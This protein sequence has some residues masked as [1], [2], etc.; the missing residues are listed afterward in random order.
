ML[1]VTLEKLTVVTAK[2]GVPNVAV[3]GPFTK[4]QVRVNVAPSG[5]DAEPLSVVELTGKVIVA[6]EPALTIG[7]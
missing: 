6:S 1:P 2:E 3:P 4:V 5:S 7:G